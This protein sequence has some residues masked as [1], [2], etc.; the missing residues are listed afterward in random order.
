MSIPNQPFYLHYPIFPKQ[1]PQVTGAPVTIPTPSQKNPTRPYIDEPV[2]PELIQFVEALQGLNQLANSKPQPN[3]DGIPLVGSSQNAVKMAL[4]GE[5]L[6]LLKEGEKIKKTV[7]EFYQSGKLPRDLVK[8]LWIHLPDADKKIDVDK[9]PYI[10]ALEQG[11]ALNVEERQALTPILNKIMAEEAKTYLSK[12]MNLADKPNAYEMEEGE[13]KRMEVTDLP[14][15]ERW[16]KNVQI[17][18]STNQNN[19]AAFSNFIPHLVD[20]MSQ[21]DSLSEAAIRMSQKGAYVHQYGVSSDS[22]ETK[23]V[24]VT[25][26]VSSNTT[27]QNAIWKKNDPNVKNRI[28]VMI[29][30]QFF[31]PL[32]DIVAGKDRELFKK[33][34]QDNYG[35]KDRPVQ[36][37]HLKGKN[38]QE[39]QEA[40][41]KLSQLATPD[42]EIA[43]R[44]DSHGTTEESTILNHSEEFSPKTIH[45]IKKTRG[46]Q[47]AHQGVV[48]FGNEN[49]FEDEMKQWLKPF[50]KAKGV[51]L[52][53]DSCF[54]GAWIAKQD[55]NSGPDQFRPN[56]SGEGLT[57]M[58]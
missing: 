36:F 57:L 7:L 49:I 16:P 21:T 56:L 14:K 4:E 43:I 45:K 40:L 11:K 48:N 55:V 3:H 8:K 27:P 12:V 23:P 22:N 58:A 42:T 47:G 1:N 2:Q 9:V 10:Q 28:V 33:G 39:I 50:S 54:S 53:V 44:L 37:V 51:M 25:P 17:H 31:N 24:P 35:S 18:T 52:I 30:D 15:D 19:S 5:S 46:L 32:Q 13:L 6:A 34:I 41:E 29:E 26:L 20:S 38:K